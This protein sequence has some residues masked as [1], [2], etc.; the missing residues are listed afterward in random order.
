MGFD[1]DFGDLVND[2]SNQLNYKFDHVYPASTSTTEVTN[3]S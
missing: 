3:S 2:E 1:V